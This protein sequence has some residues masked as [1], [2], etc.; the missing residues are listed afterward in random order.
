M[1]RN[2]TVT[3]RAGFGDFL[4]RFRPVYELMTLLNYSFVRTDETYNNLNHHTSQFNFMDKFGF[5]CFPKKNRNEY[6]DLIH[7]KD[8]TLFTKIENNS[9]SDIEPKSLLIIDLSICINRPII[10]KLLSQCAIKSIAPAKLNLK[11]HYKSNPFIKQK[12]LKVVIHLRRDDLMSVENSMIKIARHMLTIDDAMKMLNNFLVS[13]HKTMTKREIILI[14]D[15]MRSSLPKCQIVDKLAADLAKAHPNISKKF[16]G[17]DEI[18]NHNALDSLYFS[19]VII[20]VSS[21]F[22]WVFSTLYA[23]KPSQYLIAEPSQCSIKS[24]HYPI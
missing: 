12:V 14:S 3:C 15:G 7:I 1:L 2:Y 17:T 24:G 21:C 10:D 20:S 22:V 9:F 16:I 19:D 4:N 5:T 13:R 23:K 18:S 11:Y 6:L 8:E